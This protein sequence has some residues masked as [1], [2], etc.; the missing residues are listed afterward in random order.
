MGWQA[1]RG[2]TAEPFPQIVPIPCRCSHPSTQFPSAQKLVSCHPLWH[3]LV[4]TATT[5]LALTKARTDTLPSSVTWICFH[6]PTQPPAPPPKQTH[7]H[8]AVLRDVDLRALPIVLVFARE[9]LVGELVQHLFDACVCRGV[10]VK[11]RG[12]VY[13]KGGEGCEGLGGEFVQHLLHPYVIQ[14]GVGGR[15]KVGQE[16]VLRYVVRTCACV[17]AWGGPHSA[18]AER[19]RGR[20]SCSNCAR[21]KAMPDPSSMPMPMRICGNDLP[22]TPC[23][24]CMLHAQHAAQLPSGRLQPPTRQASLHPPWVGL[25]SM[26]STGTPGLKCTCVGSSSRG[27]ASRAGTNSSKEGHSL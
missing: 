22:K 12:G 18:H 1:E 5:T 19:K 24:P 25:A 15:W 27:W 20:R 14:V 26:A 23:T 4:S 6:H 17:A 8:P 9:G 21:A 13:G 7:Q 2:A 11:G 3:V 10:C 16:K